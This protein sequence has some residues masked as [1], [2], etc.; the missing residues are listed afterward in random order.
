MGVFAVTILGNN[1]AVPVHDRHPTS[2]VV[3]VGNQALLID[4]GEGTQIQ[5]MRYQIRRRKISHVFI[6]HLHGDH[7]FGLV[8]LI[9][10]FALLGRLQPLHIYAD[11]SLQQ[12][13]QLQL[14]AGDNRMP[15]E[16]IF[17]TLQEGLLVEESDFKVT[18][19]KTDHRITTYGFV[20]EE[21]KQPRRIIGSALKQYN[22]AHHQVPALR[23]G[24]NIEIDGK[25][26]E[27]AWVTTANTLPKKYAFAADT[28]YFEAILPFIK[29]VDLLYHETTYLDNLAQQAYDR[30][31]STTK[32]AAQIA[33]KAEAKKL[34]I[35]H[36]SSKYER[37]DEFLSETQAVFQNTSL[38]IEGCTFLV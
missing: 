38:A 27:N 37:L 31:H 18:A 32:Q 23:Q 17:H 15:F 6:S 7:Y 8:G 22:I 12:I 19:F 14:S 11:A 34:L 9:N 20:V 29:E 28:R 35:G 36:F 13:V 26:I 30:Y 25:I 5:M 10:S 2:Q 16:L 1:S 21:I 4:C 3:S 24:A 33:Q